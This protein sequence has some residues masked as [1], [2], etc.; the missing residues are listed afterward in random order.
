[1]SL[2]RFPDHVTDDLSSY[3]DLLS[4]DLS[5]VSQGLSVETASRISEDIDLQSAVNALSDIVSADVT[6]GTF[7]VTATG[8]TTVLT[9]T[10]NYSKSGNIVALRLPMLIGTSNSATMTLTGLP[11][12]ILPARSSYHAILVRVTTARVFG[13]AL[14]QAAT[15]EIIIYRDSA[16]SNWATNGNKGLYECVITYQLL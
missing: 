4:N 3:D 1:M 5:V 11:M 12:D 14:L 7:E 13:L 2:K 9:G 10:A 8:L 16:S 15:E 6:D